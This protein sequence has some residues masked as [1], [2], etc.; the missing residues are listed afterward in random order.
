MEGQ[1]GCYTLLADDNS[2]FAND[3]ALIRVFK[4]HL[5][6]NLILNGRIAFSD[7]QVICSANLQALAA[8]DPTL[9]AL[10]ENGLFDLAVRSRPAQGGIASL[11]SVHADFVDER[12]IRHAALDYDSTPALALFD[13]CAAKLPWTYDVIRRNYT[14]GA[15]Q[16]L[17]REFRAVLADSEFDR[18]GEILRAEKERD[19]GLGR[20]FLQNRL[21]LQ[22]RK[23][24]IR[25]D[26]SRRELIR[27]CTD[28]PY[29][30]NLPATI[31]LNPIYAHEHSASFDL[32]RGGGATFET[33]G[34]IKAPSRFDHSHYVEG[35]CRL[36]LDDV[37]FLQDLP[38]RSAYLERSGAGPTG[39]GDYERAVDAF[40]EFNL[41][42]ED[43]IAARFPEIAR[44]SPGAPDRTFYKQKA[45]AYGAAGAEDLFGILVGQFCPVA[46]LALCKQV[47]ID[48]LPERFRR[49]PRSV[50]AETVQREVTRRRLAEHLQQAGTAELLDVEERPVGGRPFSKEIVI[51]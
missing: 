8:S 50:P 17:L 28:A 18:L 49:K 41:L 44:H 5:L 10:V 16:L 2:R 1:T 51:S 36:T 6:Y 15:E 40:V 13:R 21:H 4:A 22:M 34:A 46:P 11:R 23:A 47:L 29:L 27:R 9:I 33:T 14:S 20:E 7:N 43:R 45:L 39:S 35:L 48:I 24:G 32:M 25:V 30:S 12:K 31:G 3:P 42:L 37:I 26:K 38:S 19:Q